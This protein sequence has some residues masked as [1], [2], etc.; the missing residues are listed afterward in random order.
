M[1]W[2]VSLDC[3]GGLYTISISWILVAPG[4]RLLPEQKHVETLKTGFFHVETLKNLFFSM[5]SVWR[6]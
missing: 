4:G 2:D 6:P 3:K 5:I 1:F